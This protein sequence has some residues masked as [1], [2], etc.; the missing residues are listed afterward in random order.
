MQGANSKDIPITLICGYLGSG[1]T[2]L[3]NQI[4]NTPL[5]PKRLAIL[6]NDFGDLDVDATLIKQERNDGNIISLKNGCVCCK[7]QDD[8][9]STL[10]IIKSEQIDGV[11]IEA[12]GIAIPNKLKK[13]C[14]VP[15]YDL[16]RCA[17]TIDAQNFNTKRKD[18]YV[19]YLVEQQATEGD[20]LVI[21]KTDLAPTFKLELSSKSK[22]SD[23]RVNRIEQVLSSDPNL[24]EYLFQHQNMT[25]TSD[26]TEKG[27][28]FAS[29]TLK[30]TRLIPQSKLENLVEEIPGWVER[31][32][33]TV[34]TDQ[35]VTLVQA[36]SHFRNFTAQAEPGPKGL[37]VIYPEDFSSEIKTTFHEWREWFFIS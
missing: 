14:L 31:M 9:V 20:L 11:L 26:E 19:G 5:F 25:T 6:I 3:I 32:K 1:K 15:G 4:L 30:Q 12:S 36:S 37:I 29:T 23:Q 33:G 17:V 24:T 2:T 28:G 18:K 21:T 8:L 34:D 7:I 22:S 10:E 16:G 13:Q 27:V 35:G